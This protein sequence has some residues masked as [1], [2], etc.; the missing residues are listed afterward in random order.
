MQSYVYTVCDLPFFC[1]LTGRNFDSLTPH[2]TAQ[3]QV[4]HRL[5][6]AFTMADA[7]NSLIRF[8]AVHPKQSLVRYSEIDFACSPVRL[9]V[10]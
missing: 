3:A 9:L 4:G 6:T 5:H 8:R 10:L 7:R 2:R 1:V